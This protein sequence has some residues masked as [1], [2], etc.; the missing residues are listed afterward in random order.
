MS[1]AV[2]LVTARSAWRARVCRSVWG[3]SY[4]HTNMLNRNLTLQIRSTLCPGL[5]RLALATRS[6]GRCDVLA[7]ATYYCNHAPGLTISA[8]MLPSS[9]L[10]PQHFLNFFPLPHTQPQASARRRQTLARA[11]DFNFDCR[12]GVAPR[13]IKLDCSLSH[14]A[15]GYFARSI[16][17]A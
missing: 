3:H 14:A 6:S 7:C 13:D 8:G 4:I 12:L 9:F 17:I 10:S 16:S 15:G 11:E 1:P 5:S 2:P